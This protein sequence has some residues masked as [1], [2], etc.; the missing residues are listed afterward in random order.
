M[1]YGELGRFPLEIR[2]KL[3]M[4]AFWSKLVLNENKLSS[5]LYRL[6][7]LLK[8]KHQYSFKWLNHIESIFNSTYMGF[9]FINQF[10][11]YDKSV[12]NQI[13]RDLFVQKWLCDIYS[14]SRG[15]FYSVFKKDFRIENYL[16]RLS[17]QSRIWITKFKTSNLHLPIE[18]G[19][20]YN[21]PREERI[22]HLCKETIGDEYHF[23]FV[24][25]HENIITLRNKYLPNYYRVY[26]N[27]AKLEG[28]LSIC[29][30]ELYKRLSIF[31]R[32][33]ADLL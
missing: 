3:R 26:P 24:C 10:P 20:W 22:C 11:V 15:K 25:K 21:I 32:K 5:V 7:Y 27:H 6:M 33:T 30:T 9:I 18:T 13:L 31:I 4:I 29:N 12:F 16:L 14:S 2:V 19:R 8:A 28:L 17:E 23:L 1:I